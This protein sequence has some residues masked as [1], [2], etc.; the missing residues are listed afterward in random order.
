L[1]RERSLIERWGISDKHRRTGVKVI[2]A[3]ER[4]KATANRFG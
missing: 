3:T 2:D 1:N 4:K